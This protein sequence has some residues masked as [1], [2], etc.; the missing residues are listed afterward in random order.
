M[1]TLRTLGSED[2][3]TYFLSL[4]AA[5]LAKAG[6]AGRALEA[7]REALSAAEGSGERFYT[8]ELHRQQGELVL[9]GGGGRAAAARCFETAADIARRQGAV[10]IAERALRALD[11]S[12]A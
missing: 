2:F 1:Q 7:I 6:E 9:T 3:R 12:R 11:A 4:L 5:T 8:A 10:A